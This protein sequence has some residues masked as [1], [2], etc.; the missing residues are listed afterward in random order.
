MRLS[1]DAVIFDMDGVL[2]DSEGLWDEALRQLAVDCDGIWTEEAQRVTMGMGSSAASQY[3]HEA[4][5]FKLAPAEIDS[6]LDGRIIAIYQDRIPEVP[7]AINAVRWLSSDGFA[8]GIASS[9]NRCLID[10]VLE[11]TGLISLFT[12]TVSA[13]EVAEG[14]PA[15][16]VYLEAAHRLQT[17][18]GHC[19]AVEDS[20]NG[21]RSAYAAGLRVIAL[22]NTV[23]PPSSE[24]IAL[25]DVVL[26]SFDELS[27]KVVR[28][29]V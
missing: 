7:G 8:L 20:T 10:F 26:S 15:P 6:E 29:E 17:E 2:I 14:K 25:V 1:I 24:A 27:Q 11:A 22:L 19:A 3:M 21:I 12:A 9:S 28:R 5:G 4:L 18:P 23:Y 13:E 16:D